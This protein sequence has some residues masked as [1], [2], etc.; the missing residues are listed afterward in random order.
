[1]TAEAAIVLTILGGI[2][3]T[4]SLLLLREERAAAQRRRAFLRSRGIK[5]LDRSDW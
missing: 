5:R 3:G 2:I 4:A 1:M